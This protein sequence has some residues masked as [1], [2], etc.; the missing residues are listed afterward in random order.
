[1]VRDQEERRAKIGKQQCSA[2]QISA[3]NSCC[4]SE[5]LDPRFFYG[6]LC[7]FNKNKMQKS[8][9]QGPSV[10]LIKIKCRR[11]KIS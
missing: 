9:N 6:S 4:V 3:P 1:M 7:V 2:Q 8:Q 11:V 10:S 5:N